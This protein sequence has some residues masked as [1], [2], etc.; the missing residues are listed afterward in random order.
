MTDA[1]ICFKSYEALLRKAKWG[2]GHASR[3]KLVPTNM[4]SIVQRQHK[5]NDEKSFPASQGVMKTHLEK[6][7]RADEN[8]TPHFISI[9]NLK[10]SRK[11][12]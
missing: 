8:Y 11:S 2:E 1:P 3:A 7:A 12:L 10:E 4:L 5:K 9:M 6:A